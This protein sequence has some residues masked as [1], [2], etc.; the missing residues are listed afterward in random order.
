MLVANVTR[1]GR[2]LARSGPP[3][4]TGDGYELTR[5][6]GSPKG[7]TTSNTHAGTL[8]PVETPKT[9]IDDRISATPNEVHS[10]DLMMLAALDSPQFIVRPG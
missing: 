1:N 10:T 2:F 8:S 3:E 7:T 6:I 9:P 5:L 4:I